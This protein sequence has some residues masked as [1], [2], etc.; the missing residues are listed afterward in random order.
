MRLVGR[1]SGASAGAIGIAVALAIGA[2]GAAAQRGRS[3]SRA[4]EPPVRRVEIGPVSVEMLGAEEPTRGPYGDRGE[5]VALSW[6]GVLQTLTS[7]A[8]ARLPASV[9]ARPARACGT[10]ARRREHVVPFQELSTVGADPLPAE[11]MPGPATITVS[12]E[13]RGEPY[14]ITWE[15]RD[16]RRRAGLAARERRFFASLRC[17]E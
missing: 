6:G 10:A 16:H 1:R 13:W 9:R 14:A 7:G 15:V 4:E 3:S 5:R 11:R 2:G 12:L 17:G 8:Y